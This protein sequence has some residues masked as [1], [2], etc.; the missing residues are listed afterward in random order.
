EF[1]GELAHIVLIPSGINESNFDPEEEIHLVE[2]LLC[3]NSSPRPLEEFN[4]KNS[5]AIIKSFSPSPILVEDSDSLIEEIDLFLTPDDS[6]PPGIENDDH[7][8]EVDILSLNNFLAMTS[9][10][11][12]KIS[13]FILMFHHPLV[14]LRNHQMMEFT[15]MMSPL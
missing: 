6:M 3:D 10:H 2:K 8:S 12:L 14:L 9:L 1:F 5:N 15:L 11:Y 7:D 13:H 4:S